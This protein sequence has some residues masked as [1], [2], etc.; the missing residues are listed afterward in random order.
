MECG[1]KHPN[2]VDLPR[3]DLQK[4]SEQKSCERDKMCFLS[5]CGSRYFLDSKNV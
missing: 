1:G 3:F 5:V 4:A 2:R